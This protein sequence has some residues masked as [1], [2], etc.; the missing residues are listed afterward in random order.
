VTLATRSRPRRRRRRGRGLALWGLRLVL[1]LALFAT[2][3][4]LGRALEEN[5]EPGG[6]VTNRGTLTFTVKTE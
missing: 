5:P 1:A 4:A 2:G 6:N 3:V